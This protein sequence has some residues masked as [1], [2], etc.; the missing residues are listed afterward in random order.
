MTRDLAHPVAHVC[1]VCGRPSQLDE[2]CWRHGGSYGIIIQ[3]EDLPRTLRIG[4]RLMMTGAMLTVAL[5]ILTMALGGSLTGRD[6]APDAAKLIGLVM[7]VVGLAT[8]VVAMYL[9]ELR[10][11]AW[12]VAAGLLGVVGVVSLVLLFAA[13][14]SSSYRTLVIV[15]TTL[16]Y[17]AGAALVG[18]WRAQLPPTSLPQ[19]SAGGAGRAGAASS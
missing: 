14:P 5:G 16:P 2:L 4:L 1:R 17:L 9:S 7:I 11:W 19:P 10:A 13:S 18:V 15:A 3:T 6:D 12:P 8:V